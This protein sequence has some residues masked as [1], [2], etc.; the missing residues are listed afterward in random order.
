MQHKLPISLKFCAYFK[1]MNRPAPKIISG[2]LNLTRTKDLAV[3][4][5]NKAPKT[6]FKSDGFSSYQGDTSQ[7]SRRVT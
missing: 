6:N 5:S 3:L 7:T 1:V 4:T 2:P